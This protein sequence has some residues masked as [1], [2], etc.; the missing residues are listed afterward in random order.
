MCNRAH[1]A[2]P[3][4]QVCVFLTHRECGA[5]ARRPAG[6]H[7]SR[8]EHSAGSAVWKGPVFHSLMDV[9]QTQPE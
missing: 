4:T 3:R 1:K 9:K 5:R 6:E 7:V 8:P 2:L